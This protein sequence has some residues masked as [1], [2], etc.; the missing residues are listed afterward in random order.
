MKSFRYLVEPES[1]AYPRDFYVQVD[2][3]RVPM[4]WHNLQFSI[5]TG[6]TVGS[7]TH[8]GDRFVGC[9]HKHLTTVLEHPS[10]NKEHDSMALA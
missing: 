8:A 3:S 5:M 1:S 9:G 10:M 4:Q 7:L 6:G 2:Q